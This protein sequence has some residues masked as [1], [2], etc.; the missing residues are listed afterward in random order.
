MA[1]DDVSLGN[2]S[3]R[4]N[5]ELTVNE[6]DIALLDALF[7]QNASQDLDLFQQLLIGDLFLGP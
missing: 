6:N 3:V 5:R 1:L 2:S 4:A 7:S